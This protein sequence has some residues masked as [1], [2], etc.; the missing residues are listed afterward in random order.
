M[1]ALLLQVHEARYALPCRSVSAVVPRVTMRPVPHA[2][3]WLAGVF[4]YRGKVTPVVDLCEL[5]GGYP[6][7]DRLSSRIVLVPRPASLTGG[8]QLGLLTERVTEA[9]ELDGTKAP[10]V[11]PPEA[12]YLGD[13]VLTE[14]GLIQLLDIDVICRTAESLSAASGEAHGALPDRSAP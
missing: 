11:R 14:S 10:G 13:V 3:P 9:V 4:V 6:C 1:L 2:P 7:P 12:A 8:D 5:I